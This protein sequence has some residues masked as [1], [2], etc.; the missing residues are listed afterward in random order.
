MWRRL[1]L[2]GLL[3]IG[4]VSSGIAAQTGRD[5]YTYFFNDTFGDF[6]EELQRAREEG[7]QGIFIFFEM[8]ECPFCHYMKEH[9]L[10]QPRVQAYYRQHFLNFAVD[11]EG[12]VEITD[13]QGRPTTMKDFAFK[14]YRVR[15]TPVL[16]FFDLNGKLVHRYTGRTKGVDEFLWLGEYVAEGHYRK[17]SFTRFKRMKRQAQRAGGADRAQ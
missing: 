4:G 17:M 9:V 12:D 8:D 1:I 11:I 16:A 7:K 10:N 13:F 14:Q 3:F 5:P 15:A 6:Q 2:L